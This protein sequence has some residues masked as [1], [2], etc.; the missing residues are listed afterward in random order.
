MITKKIRTD[1]QEFTPPFYCAS[2]ISLVTAS[3]V[4]VALNARLILL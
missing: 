3:H 2:L 4:E 1:G